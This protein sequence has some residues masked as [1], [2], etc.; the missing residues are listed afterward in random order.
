[1]ARLDPGL[2]RIVRHVVASR[3]RAV[4]IPAGNGLDT[5]PN[6]NIMLELEGDEAP[7]GLLDLGFTSRTKAG[8][9]LTGQISREAIEGLAGVP[10]LKRAE[11]PR[12]LMLDLDKALPDAD[13]IPVASQPPTSRGDGVVIGIV[14][15][16]ID[17][18]HL[19]FRREDAVGTTRILALWDQSLVPSGNE[20]S[21]HP[22]GYG[23]EYT[24]EDIDG[25]LAAAAGTNVRHRDVAPFHGTHVSS[26][27]AGGGR[28]PH[29]LLGTRLFGVAPGADLVVV[30]NTR[31]RRL[32]PGTVGDSADTLDAIKY[33]LDLAK[34][35]NRPVAIN[36]S[37]GDNVGPHDG[38]SLLELGIAALISE[39]GRVLVKSAG[40]EG[41]ALTHA[42][43][44]LRAAEPQD[45]RISV[46]VG[47]VELVIDLWYPPG[48]RISVTVTPPDGASSGPFAPSQS[49][50][51]SLPNGNEL[52]VDLDLDD[53]GNGHNRI[54]IA[55]EA[56][57]PERLQAGTWTLRLDGTGEWHAWIQ[58]N[59]GS[60]FQPPFANAASTVT[61]P[62]TAASAITVGAHVSRSLLRHGKLSKI[63]SRGPTRAGVL[64]P[65]LTAP[66]ES[67]IAAQPGDAFVAQKGSSMAAAMVTGAA[68]L[69]L[70]I[71]G[72]LTAKDIQAILQ[73][74]ARQDL[75][76]GNTPSNEWGHGKLDI[77]SAC[78][79]VEARLE[80]SGLT[81]VVHPPLVEL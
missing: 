48:D 34:A 21:P 73:K 24:R 23:V 12:A 60:T 5:G 38:T 22:F 45:V 15:H 16:G 58:R 59:S 56:A 18:R 57:G 79:M 53:P 39:P 42:S 30:A 29:P 1:M 8:R 62:G 6:P 14:D 74:T 31:A 76:T 36:L 20:Q 43:G 32:D 37:Q 50:A 66:G 80:R 44:T 7:Q 71:D 46:P 28:P 61:V 69:M 51:A 9:I 54:Y 27:A 11:A 4:P 2:K 55:L 78:K 25:A 68:A 72:T 63:S 33:I 10:G 47:Q 77:D 19:T 64:A 81:S 70:A 52:F 3:D 40:N 49:T 65:T 17:F 26:I 35:H 67:I 41:D 75:H 13:L